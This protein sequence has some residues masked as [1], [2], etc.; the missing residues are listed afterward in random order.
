[1]RVE[2]VRVERD[3]HADDDVADLQVLAAGPEL[4]DLAAELVAHHGVGLRV[5]HDRRHAGR[6]AGPSF[7]SSL[8]RRLSSPC[9]SRCR[10]LPQMPQASTL[11]STCPGPGVGS[12]MS[13]TRS[14]QSRITA[15]RMAATCT[16]QR[17]MGRRCEA[18]AREVGDRLDDH[19]ERRRRRRCRS[20]TVQC[21]GGT[22]AQVAAG[23]SPSCRGCA[24][25]GSRPRRASAS[26]GTAADG[27]APARRT[28]RA[29]ARRAGCRAAL[30]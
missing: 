4:D 12:G 15:A 3:G 20:D 11:V 21:R 23:R 6:A 26:A 17:S 10:S 30:T 25:R 28:G 19:V 7:S 1:M 14:C 8:S 27:S 5:E 2:A 9:T 22:V 13:S 24:R 18:S 29:P 16:W